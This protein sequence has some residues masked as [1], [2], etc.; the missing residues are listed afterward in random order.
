SLQ[1]VIDKLKLKKRS[2]TVLRRPATGATGALASAT[3]PD[4]LLGHDN[5]PDKR[6]NTDAV[7][8]G[9][10]QLAAAHVTQYQEARTLPLAEVRDR[11]RE[12]VIATR[13][14]DLARKDGEAK[15]AQ[16]KAE[17]SA[18][19]PEKATLSRQERGALP[20]QVVD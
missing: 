4:A 10:N 11:V 20:P 6:K 16:L 3:L 8:V 7:E 14:G 2:A 15:L 13:A 19:L 12:R 9:P 17:P 18:A 1:P 5:G